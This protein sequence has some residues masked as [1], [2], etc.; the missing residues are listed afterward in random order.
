VCEATFSEGLYVLI[1]RD[2]AVAATFAA[3]LVAR[4]FL[5]RRRVRFTNASLSARQLSNR[6]PTA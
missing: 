4:S 1:E 6:T 5:M 2:Y 3:S